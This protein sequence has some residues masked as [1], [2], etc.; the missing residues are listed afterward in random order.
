MFFLYSAYFGSSEEAE[1]ILAQAGAKTRVGRSEGLE[2]LYAEDAGLQR[3]ATFSLSWLADVHAVL[4]FAGNSGNAS[5][6]SSNQN[7]KEFGATTRT[8]ANRKGVR[9]ACCQLETALF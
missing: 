8:R 3:R 5:N 9:F 2:Y 6:N 4:F 1:R 7:A